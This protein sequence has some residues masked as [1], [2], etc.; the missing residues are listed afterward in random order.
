VW[1]EMLQSNAAKGDWMS[2]KSI[3]SGLVK[4]S[5]VLYTMPSLS[6]SDINDLAS[7]NGGIKTV[8]HS[9]NNK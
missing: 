2:Y 4:G 8:K 3:A 6:T 5:G 1:D 7:N 9:T